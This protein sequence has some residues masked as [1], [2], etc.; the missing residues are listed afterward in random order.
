[1]IRTHNLSG[2]TTKPGLLA[3]FAFLNK[4]GPNPASF[5]LF[6]FFSQHNDKSSTKFD[7]LKRRW[8]TWESNLGL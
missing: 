6:L 7:I 3:T 8:C 5:C 1:M 4:Y 2:M